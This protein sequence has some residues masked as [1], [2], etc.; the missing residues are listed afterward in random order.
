MADPVAPLGA[1]RPHVPRVTERPPNPPLET[2]PYLVM[3]RVIHELCW[4]AVDARGGKDVRGQINPTTDSW[5]AAESQARA[6]S[7]RWGIPFTTFD[8]VLVEGKAT[9]RELVQIAA[10]NTKVEFYLFDSR[11]ISL[12]ERL[13]ELGDS[14][15]DTNIR[16]SP[17]ETP[18]LYAPNRRASGL[19]LPTTSG[20]ALFGGRWA[21]L[22]DALAEIPCEPPK[23]LDPELAQV[24]RAVAVGIRECARLIASIPQLWGNET[25]YRRLAEFVHEAA[26]S[27]LVAHAAVDVRLRRA[28]G[29]NSV[30]DALN[31]VI[32]VRDHSPI[33]T[34]DLV[35]GLDGVLTKLYTNKARLSPQ[36]GGRGI[37]DQM[38]EQLALVP[39]P[40]VLEARRQES[41]ANSPA[42]AN[43]ALLDKAKGI[44]A[45]EAEVRV[46][47][48]LAAN[49]KADPASITR[50][51]V[52]AGAGVSGGAVSKSAAW[53]AFRQRRDADST[54]VPREVPLSNAMLVNI[55]AV[56]DAEEL[57]A[58]I[59][60]QAEDDASDERG[61]GKKSRRHERRHGSS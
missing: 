57:D 29:P 46:R 49:A 30:L 61:Q 48:W 12:E 21:S 37:I 7:V 19:P 4:L 28:G 11:Y 47:E 52:A 39:P 36:S 25:E 5:S 15:P 51:A 53:K 60:Q 9:M 22:D 54:P 2:N 16:Y 34:S 38:L 27:A 58:L 44:P 17:E 23:G 33:N 43:R 26:K 35:G 3:R 18:A 32:T 56:G 20:S 41:S 24:Y 14:F 13:K 10:G 40:A 42:D 31:H 8:P 45:S 59:R 1:D 50:D 55:P 6:S